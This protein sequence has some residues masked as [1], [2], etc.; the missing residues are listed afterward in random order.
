MGCSDSWEKSKGVDPAG[1]GLDYWFRREIAGFRKGQ[2]GVG[3]VRE[4]CWGADEMH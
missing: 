1:T 4:G 2:G 3:L